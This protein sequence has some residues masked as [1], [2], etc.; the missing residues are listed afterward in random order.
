[1]RLNKVANGHKLKYR[2]ILGAIKVASG[3]APDVVRVFF[4]RPEF[5]GKAFSHLTHKAMRG[6][7]FWT[8]GERELFAAWT[9]KLNDCEF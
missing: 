6:P 5:F 4:Y 7:S 2:M 1:M 9:S 8:A 3:G